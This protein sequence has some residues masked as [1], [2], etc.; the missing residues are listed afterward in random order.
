MSY[1]TLA[2]FGILLVVQSHFVTP[3]RSPVD[4]HKFDTNNKLYK[5]TLAAFVKFAT[6]WG[7]RYG[8]VIEKVIEDL[9]AEGKGHEN[10]DEIEQLQEIVELSKHL[11]GDSDDETLHN[12]MDFDEEEIN[13]DEILEQYAD[14]DHIL[15]LVYKDGK[16]VVK[17]FY[18]NLVKFVHGFS[19]ALEKYTKDMSEEERA[20]HK[21]FFEW[22]NKFEEL[23]QKNDV[24]AQSHMFLDFFKLFKPN[25]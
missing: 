23:K 17:E 1:R 2:F 7:Q 15:A 25:I 11:K 10:V 5:G 14:M 12:I 24:I 13:T 8:Q 22:F 6:Q 18:R 9:K 19:K 4:D 16:D 21:Q 3:E 20:E